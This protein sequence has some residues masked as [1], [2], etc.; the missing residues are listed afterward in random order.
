MCVVVGVAR[1]SASSEIRQGN[2]ATPLNQ[3]GEVATRPR[4]STAVGS[5]SE[6]KSDVETLLS[7]V[8]P[9]SSQAARAVP[10]LLAA[11]RDSETDGTLRERSAAMLARIGEPAR[12]AVPVLIEILNRSPETISSESVGA[13]SVGAGATGA[14]NLVTTSYWS[15]KCL[16]VFGSVAAD[17]VPAVT[18]VLTSPASSSKLRVLAADTLGQI[19]DS[20]AIGVLTAELMKPRRFSDYDS[21]VLRQTIIDSLALA[22][23]LAVGAIPALGRAAEDDNADVRRKACYALGSL[24]PR[25]E[26]AMNALLERLILD[27]DAAVKDAAANALAQV[28]EPAVDRLVDLLNRGGPDLQWRAAQALGQVGAS[29]KPAVESLKLAFGSPS[30]DVRIEAIDAVWK[31]SRDSHAVATV[32]VEALAEDDRQ[33]RRR[34]AGLLVE[35]KQL[36]RETSLKLEQ[37]AADGNSNESRAAAHVLRERS[38]KA[39]Q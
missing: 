37:L 14:S 8:D 32:L 31:I 2:S 25:A 13:V 33:I 4:C 35:L 5:A 10:V 20:A 22:G 36:P 21:I 9:S 1:S 23:P 6:N 19:G 3:N 12:A 16:G 24:G 38:R 15:M 29:A 11:L 17:A 39:D 27:E 30:A 18:R 34:A 7:E 26:G 28:G